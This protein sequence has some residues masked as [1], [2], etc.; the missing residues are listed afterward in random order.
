MRAYVRVILGSG[1]IPGGVEMKIA[2]VTGASAG[3]GREM[4]IRLNDSIPNIEEFWLIGRRKEAL[5]DLERVLTKPA[6]LI[7]LDLSKDISLEQ[8]G[9]LLISEKPEIIF[10]VNAAGFG[11]IGRV[12]DLTKREQLGMIDV[13]IR[14][15]TEL[16]RLSL[17]YMAKH[18]RIIQFA[19][20]AAFL[21]QPSFA[22]YA[23]G[24]SFVLSFSRA[25]NEELRGTGCY[26]TAVCPGPV[27]TA[28]F[29]GAETTGKI[30]LYK[31][32][33]MADPKKV[34]RLALY[35]SVLKKELSIYGISMKVFYVL[36]KLLPTGLIFR[37]M[38][39]LNTF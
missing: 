5:V 4:A 33:F 37:I 36:T 17:P 20:A 6:R 12:C 31:Y 1:I 8:Y 29:D 21:P 30:P 19:S 28:F 13:N 24:K 15:L 9:E 11:Q 3:M 39:I 14:A 27:K 35:D 34:V 38:R 16:T 26:A 2:V 18:S 22:V 7:S 25:L 10:L 32:L 23:A